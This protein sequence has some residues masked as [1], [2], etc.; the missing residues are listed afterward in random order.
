MNI[1]SGFTR[2]FGGSWIKVRFYQRLPEG[3]KPAKTGPV[4]FCDALEKSRTTSLLLDRNDICCLGGRYIFGEDP[5]IHSEAIEVCHSKRGIPKDEIGTA[6]R[7]IPSLKETKFIGFNL[8]SLPDMLISYAQPESI[9]H[10]LDRYNKR[11]DIM[12]SHLGV[13]G[14][15]GNVIAPSYKSKK[16]S[17]FFGCEG[18][19]SE[20]LLTRD[21]VIIGVPEKF[22]NI[23]LG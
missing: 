23:L 2:K 17:L 4:T 20:G 16:I 14:V 22:F 21:R 19:R 12:I 7:A 18:I 5:D 10:I 9:M 8:N 13:A 6:L 1:L 11:E 3:A 15:C